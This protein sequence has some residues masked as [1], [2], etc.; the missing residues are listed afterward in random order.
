M[1]GQIALLAAFAEAVAGRQTDEFEE[2]VKAAYGA[3]TALEDLLAA[4]E[5]GR[6]LGEPPEPV[7]AEAYATV[8][9]WQWMAMRPPNPQPRTGS[10]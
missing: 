10:A 7:V 3:G 9:A 4:L 2:V 5:I 1:R 6:L 8:H